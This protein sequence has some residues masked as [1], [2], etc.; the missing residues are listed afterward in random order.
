MVVV[1]VAWPPELDTQEYGIISSARTGHAGT[2]FKQK[3]AVTC[4]FVALFFLDTPTHLV[5]IEPHPVKVKDTVCLCN[6][7]PPPL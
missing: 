6:E 7:S 2:A 4:Q 3:Q 5:V 1:F